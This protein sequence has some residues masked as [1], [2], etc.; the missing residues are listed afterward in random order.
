[1]IGDM[2]FGKLYVLRVSTFPGIVVAVMSNEPS[3]TNLWHACLRHISAY[4]ME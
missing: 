2:N 4:G 3:K 1:M